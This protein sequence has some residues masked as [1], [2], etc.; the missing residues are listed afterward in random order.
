MGLQ[1]KGEIPGVKNARCKAWLVAKGYN[2]KEGID[3]DE[4]FSPTVKHTSIRVLLAIVAQS[5]LELEHLDMKTAFLHEELEETIYMAQLEGY[6]VEGKEDYVCRLKK[7][8]YSLKQ[9]SR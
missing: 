2:Q 1:E 5:D 3:Y 8:L 6:Y 7:S 9:S 4:M